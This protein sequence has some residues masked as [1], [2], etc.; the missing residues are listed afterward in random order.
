M[1]TTTPL[2]PETANAIRQIISSIPDWQT[3]PWSTPAM[4]G[5]PIIAGGTEQ[6][7]QPLPWQKRAWG[8]PTVRQTVPTPPPGEQWHHPGRA[9]SIPDD[10]S[11]K[12][13]SPALQ[14]ENMPSLFDQSQD[15][16]VV[17]DNL[18]KALGA[19][20]SRQQLSDIL[21]QGPIGKPD[22]EQPAQDQQAQEPPSLSS[23]IASGGISTPTF[24]SPSVA[25]D[26][27]AA[28]VARINAEV[29]KKL[30][31]APSPTH[32]GSSL[33]PGFNDSPVDP[34]AGAKEAAARVAALQASDASGGGSRFQGAVPG[35]NSQDQAIFR[36]APA[37]ADYGPAA[38]PQKPS[39]TPPDSIQL[40]ANKALYQGRQADSL[41]SR[42]ANVVAKAKLSEALKS[43]IPPVL[44][45]ALTAG[46][47]TGDGES[48]ASA[49]LESPEIRKERIA[50]KGRIDLQNQQNQFTAGENKSNRTERE[51]DREERAKAAADLNA[52]SRDN[53]ST[54]MWGQ[55][56]GHGLQ[57]LGGLIGA[58]M[59]NANTSANTEKT[60]ASHERVAKLETDAKKEDT[61]TAKEAVNNPVVR[62]AAVKQLNPSLNASEALSQAGAPAE[63]VNASLR[64]E[65]N[66]IAKKYNMK[67]DVGI[68]RARSEAKAAGYGPEIVDAFFGGDRTRK[69][70]IARKQAA[71]PNYDPETDEH[72]P[73]FEGG[74]LSSLSEAIGLFPGNGV[75]IPRRL[76]SEISKPIAKR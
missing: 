2:D 9:F 17:L 34:D 14:G 44:A 16:L 18:R 10:L 3:P 67:S 15:G 13:V 37:A 54:N 56:G 8:E 29:A 66:D 25:K 70:A 20:S 21:A 5:K 23:A 19:K 45:M 7:P 60:L 59:T 38:G 55:I 53:A 39:G 76:P 6:L 30:G 31:P 65:L 48:L 73:F 28:T 57:T 68:T 71:D 36:G 12:P 63:K 61:Q 46:G 69:A 41:A 26:D 35:I 47:Q 43:G 52:T 40:A 50:N 42:Q 74:P 4:P 58:Y 64:Q 33:P 27:V 22:E 1:P 51:A 49:L 11:Q 32:W 24:A 72:L 75:D 62:A